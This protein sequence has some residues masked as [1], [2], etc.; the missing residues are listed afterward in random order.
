MS[1]KSDSLA[2]IFLSSVVWKKMKPNLTI[3][4]KWSNKDMHILMNAHI[5]A[6]SLIDLKF[7]FHLVHKFHS[8]IFFSAQ[9][10]MMI[11]DW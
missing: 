1:Q 5:R 11:K 2:T 4:Q 8:F 6:D 10:L 9:I 3:G 7:A